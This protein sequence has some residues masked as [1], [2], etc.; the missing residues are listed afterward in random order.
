MIITLS[1][2]NRLTFEYRFQCAEYYYSK[3]DKYCR[4][5]PLRYTCD[6]GGSRHCMSGKI[7]FVCP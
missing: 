4:P 3:C 1:F 7:V 6:A 5:D 2:I